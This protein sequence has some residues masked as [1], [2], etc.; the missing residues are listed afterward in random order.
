MIQYTKD[1]ETVLKEAKLLAKSYDMDYVGTE[2]VVEAMLNH[3]NLVCELLMREY[4]AKVAF[5][6]AA[7]PDLT[8]AQTQTKRKTP[9]MTP[10]LVRV[11][12]RSREFAVLLN[13]EYVGTGHIMLSVLREPE[14]M[15]VRKLVE[16]GIDSAT[17]FKQI[18]EELG[19]TGNGAKNFLESLKAKKKA[20][21]GGYLM[22]Y[23]RDLTELAADGKT[24]PVVGRN[25]EIGRLIQTLCRKKKNN[26]CLIGEPGVGKTA[27]V[28]GL[29]LRIAAGTVP[30]LMKDKRI[31]SLNMASLVAGSKY[32]GE[33]EERMRQLLSELENNKN[34]I[35]FIDEVHTIIGAGSGEGSLDAANIMKPALS[36]G[37]IQLI[38]TTTLTEYRKHIEKDAALERRFQPITVEE[39]SEEEACR[40]LEGIRAGY[41]KHHGIRY[42]DEAI[43]A[44]VTLSA[45]YINDRHL[46]DKAIDLLDEAGSRVKLNSFL[47]SPD[48][49]TVAQELTR[50]QSDKETA[51]LNGNTEE[52][53]KLNA[54]IR[55][56]SRKQKK[57]TAATK[58]QAEACVTEET[59]AELV[60]AQTGIP[61][62]RINKTE[63][64]RLLAMEEELHRFVI[65]QEEAIS[66]LSKSIRRGRIGLKDPN[67]PIGSFLFLGPTG[68]GKTE[69]CKA[70]AETLFGDADAMIRI[71]MSE[72]MEKHSVSKMIGSPPG[73]VGFEEGGQ[74]SERVR[75]KPYSVLLLDE[76]EKAHPD[77]FNI[78][79]QV[80]DDG[81]I[82]DS[83]GRKVD[84][85]NTVI[86]MTS[87]AGATR[88]MNPKT[89][90][91]ATEQ[92]AA[93]DY[94]RM[95]E[96]VMEEVRHLFK[97]EFL[98]R[99]DEI[100]VFHSLTREEVHGIAEL[101][102]NRFA[103]KCK[104]TANLTVHFTEAL[105]DAVASKGY[106]PL[107]GARPVKRVIQD[108]VENAL[109]EALLK[110]TV[111]NGADVTLD[112]KDNEVVIR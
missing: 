83:N 71:D 35:L 8:S 34:I 103:K 70:L 74:L 13:D 76:I 4:G 96:G 50:L 41:E 10:K 51:F 104:S 37:L 93:R 16:Y 24:E 45:R 86:V 81:R 7:N 33:F 15:A 89:L 40:I 31:L 39:P 53:K 106:D 48:T 88:I 60:A 67:R 19:I 66:A 65:G 87:N 5:F 25:E 11:L 30:E 77:V 97:P 63:R 92:D 12:E 59:I 101:L 55:S 49:M 111:E 112:W 29:A 22:Q 27:V 102:L 23:C 47:T 109:T 3:D 80:L 78:L 26:P 20:E 79:L 2:H 21:H 32:R 52:V 56:L 18:L 91:F 68:V 75:R 9:E 42:T 98:N 62:S 61:V 107:Y 36:K 72:Y 94:N 110:G 1:A 14:S 64:E 44:C 58:L 90:G 108:T 85:K 105:T 82:T 99:I 6:S 46:P 38:G 95:K 57:E 17:L 100:L 69:L 84:F 73:Y 54:K 28:E 43:R